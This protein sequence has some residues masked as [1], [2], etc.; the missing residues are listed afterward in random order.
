MP[1]AFRY[2]RP[3]LSIPCL[4]W[5]AAALFLPLPV[6]SQTAACPAIAQHPATQADI[7]YSE[8]SYRKAEDLYGAALAQR[9]HDLQLSAALV[10]TWLHQERCLRPFSS[11]ARLRSGPSRSG[12]GCYTHWQRRSPIFHFVT[13]ATKCITDQHWSVR[14]SWPASFCT[15]VVTFSGAGLQG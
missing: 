3:V 12:D 2:F 11:A 8:G 6:F 15:S 10:H 13:C 4:T 5:V 14:C 9:P 7:A 1:I